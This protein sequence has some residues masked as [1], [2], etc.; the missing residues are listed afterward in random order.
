MP[1][2]SVDVVPS[3]ASEPSLSELISQ[4]SVV[5]VSS[6]MPPPVF[7]TDVAVTTSPVST[8]QSSSVIPIC[9]R[10]PLLTRQ[11]VLEIPL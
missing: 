3:T 5:A 4:A 9:L 2:T 6:S 8:P 1:L 10:R 7:T 11:L